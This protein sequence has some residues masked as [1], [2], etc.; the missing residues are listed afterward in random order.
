MISGL[1]GRQHGVVARRQLLQAGITRHQVA[2]RLTDGRLH[3]VHRGVYL[4]GHTVPPP[5][6]REQAA[7]L[8]C[9]PGAVLSH[10]TA[11]ALWSLLAYPVA[12][13][14][15]V[16]LRRGRTAAR[17]GITT[18]RA[19]LERR[20]VRR[21][22][23]LPLT[24]PPRTILDL[25]C[26]LDRDELELVVAEA[27]YRR[28]ATER[29]LR[30][31][32]ERNPGKRG[33]A[34][35]RRVLELAGGPQRTRSVAER[36]MLRLLRDAGVTGYEANARIHGYE[37][38]LL[39]REHGLAVEIDGYAGHSGRVAFERDRLKIATLKAHGV[40]VVP[41]TP[42]RIRDDP[43]GTLGRLLRAL[44]RAGYRAAA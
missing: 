5:H 21:R 22:H 1:A 35:L 10:R 8:A 7:L 33:N 41:V 13:P 31:Q 11:G 37:V 25:A 24:S 4:V 3:E 43:D 42:R 40:D 6:A 20:D 32:L 28:L 30:D 39:W 16:T 15:R 2:L 12:A 36:R 18:H 44:E 9:V 17:P 29:E 14:V 27:S 19:T 34:S 38:D 23:G 26:E